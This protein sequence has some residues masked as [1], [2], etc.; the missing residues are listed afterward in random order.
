MQSFYDPELGSLED[1]ISSSGFSLAS[2]DL[3]GWFI[4]ADFKSLFATRAQWDA[5]AGAAP[6]QVDSD[7][8][9]ILSSRDPPPLDYFR[10]LDQIHRRKEWAVYTLLLEHSE[11]EPILYV[12]S[13]TDGKDRVRVRYSGSPVA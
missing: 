6:L 12:G 9:S 1:H 4:N 11:L 8:A 13:G 3:P 5:V 7:L 10:H 2:L